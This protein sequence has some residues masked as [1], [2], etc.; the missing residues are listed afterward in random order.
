VLHDVVDGHAGVGHPARGVDVEVDVLLG[1]PGLEEEHLGDDQV[2][3]LVVDLLAQE[4]DPLTQQ[5]RVDVEGPVARLPSSMTVGTRICCGGAVGRAC[6]GAVD[7]GLSSVA[8]GMAPR[9]SQ[10]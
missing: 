3:H 6:G 2:G 9:L 1:I 8:V 7:M 4:D 5:L 10:I